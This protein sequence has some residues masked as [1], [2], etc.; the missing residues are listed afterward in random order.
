MKEGVRK[1]LIL[2]I[3]NQ[4]RADDGLGWAFIDQI[5]DR[6]PDHFDYEY[7][8]QLQIEDAELLSHYD[9]VC[10]VDADKQNWEQGFKYTRCEPNG[11]HGFSTH[12]LNPE[13]VLYLTNTIYKK[14]PKAN[15]IGISGHSF[16]LEIGLTEQAK[17]NLT[18]AV[19]FF[20]E[21]MVHLIN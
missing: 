5:K 17:A 14:Y 21:K 10:F 3:G 18:R 12:A 15:I 19:D 7:K 6:L 11:G 2:G 1:I 4:G 13:T 16:E 20:S 9:E 8:Y